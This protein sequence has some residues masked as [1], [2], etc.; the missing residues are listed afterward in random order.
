VGLLF[1]E[2]GHP[3]E[4]R[5][6][7]EQAREIL[8][9]LVREN[10]IIPADASGLGKDLHNLA[11]IEFAAQR[12]SAARDRLQEAIDWQ[13]KALALSPQNSE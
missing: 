7:Y 6:A 13:K 12:F 5:K 4:A 3:D 11:G 9:R 2:T 8:E 1:R 10:P